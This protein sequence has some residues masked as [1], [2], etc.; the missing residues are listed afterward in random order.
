[1]TSVQLSATSAIQA[2]CTQLIRYRSQATC[3]TVPLAEKDVLH[4]SVTGIKVPSALSV[5]RG[6]QPP[7]ERA[8]N[9]STYSPGPRK[10]AAHWVQLAAYLN[11][12]PSHNPY[13]GFVGPKDINVVREHQKDMEKYLDGWEKNWQE[14]SASNK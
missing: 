3:N 9:A 12:P 10:K 5:D 11:S 6:V 2:V 1:M 7:A 14:M 8:P 13:T 4:E